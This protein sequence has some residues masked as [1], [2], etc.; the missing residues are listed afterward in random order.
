MMRI[1]R[2]LGMALAAVVVVLVL[3]GVAARF[4]D[5]PL[6][7]FPGG[8]LHAG[9]LVA[10]PEIDWSALADVREVELQLVTPPRSRTTWLLV[11]DGTA[12]VPCGLPTLRF[13][14]H[15]PYELAEDGRVI[16]RVAGKRY[17]RLAVRVTDRD[18]WQALAAIAQAKYG[19]GA[20]SYP[21][22]VWFF[23]LEPRPAR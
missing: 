19:I 2:W 6:G 23:R 18:E 17:E 7:P 13:F 9:E 8:P 20:P 15:W 4:M 12:Y 10:D 11:R 21:D 14:K 5:G 1:L 3:V 22:E 16:L